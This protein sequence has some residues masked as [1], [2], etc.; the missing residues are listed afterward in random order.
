MPPSDQCPSEERPMLERL[1]ACI[2]LVQVE[3][4]PRAYALL[5]GEGLSI[6]L[7]DGLD[8]DGLE[9]VVHLRVELPAAVRQGVAFRGSG[10]HPYLLLPCCGRAG[11]LGLLYLELV[12]PASVPNRT[13]LFVEL[14]SRAVGH[15]DVAMVTTLPD[16]PEQPTE[17]MP[18]SAAN[19]VFVLERNE[20][21]ISRVAR[22]LGVT[23]M[24][25]YNR[26]RSARVTRVR[27]PKSP[28]T[29]PALERKSA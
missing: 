27:V 11:L 2:Q 24:T 6:A 19:L 28:R 23:R 16:Q 10:R 20:W 13:Q 17:A 3:L 9:D 15:D 26:L 7:S 21:N 14:L 18:A 22:I 4:R 8:G 29:Q 25:I 5:L 12:P 1:A